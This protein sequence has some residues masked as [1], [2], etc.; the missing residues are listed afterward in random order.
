M[1]KTQVAEAIS[2][3][4]VIRVKTGVTSPEFPEVSHAG[5]AGNV[6]ELT[7]KKSALKYVIEWNDQTIDDIPTEYRDLCEQ[8][9]LF[10]R[11]A[12]FDAKQ[13]ERIDD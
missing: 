8:N 2:I 13:I 1:S 11:M 9:N 6:V 4:T 7:G 10:Y 5:W 3:G 12:C